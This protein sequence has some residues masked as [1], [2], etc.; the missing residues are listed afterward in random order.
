VSW[1]AKLTTSITMNLWKMERTFGM[2]LVLR[3]TVTQL[4]VTI[5]SNFEI[6]V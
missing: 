6:I 1:L 5:L 3:L 4:Y 2:Q